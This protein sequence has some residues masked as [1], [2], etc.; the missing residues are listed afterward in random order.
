MGPLESLLVISKAAVSRAH[1]PKAKMSMAGVRVI[2][3]S[4][5]EGRNLENEEVLLLSSL[6]SMAAHSGA[7]K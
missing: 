5:L 4:I 1:I 7:R 3:S 6:L 2:V